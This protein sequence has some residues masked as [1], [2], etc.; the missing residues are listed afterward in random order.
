MYLYIISIYTHIFIFLQTLTNIIIVNII[1]LY[2]I[3]ILGYIFFII[4]CMSHNI[5]RLILS[6][7]HFE[8]EVTLRAV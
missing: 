4:I 1:E 7:W 6:Y 3:Y 2:I 5:T 8:Q